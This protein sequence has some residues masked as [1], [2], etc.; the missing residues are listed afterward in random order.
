MP[1]TTR[2]D[3]APESREDLA[4]PDER[5]DLPNGSPGATLDDPDDV[6][7]PGEPA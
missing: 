3:A 7:E 6:A 1:D 5:P 2:D 4:D